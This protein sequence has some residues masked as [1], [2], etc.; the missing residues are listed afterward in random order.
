M[1][2]VYAL[3]FDLSIFF[4]KNMEPKKLLQLPADW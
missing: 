4:Y 2:V 1:W 3:V